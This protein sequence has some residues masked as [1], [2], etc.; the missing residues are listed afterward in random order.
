MT[1]AKRGNLKLVQ[2]INRSLVLNLIRDRGPLSRADISRITKLTRSTVSEIV[3]YLI[4]EGWVRENGRSRSQGGR[5]GILVELNPR[6]YYAVGVEIGTLNIVAALVDLRGKVTKRV[7]RL[8]RREQ[9]KEIVIQRVKKTIHELI[10]IS[11]VSLSKIA[12]IGVAVPGLIDSER[13]I[14]RVSSN[15]G[16][17][18]V[19]LREILE[20]E[21]HVPILVDNNANAMALAESQFGAGKG[22]KNFVCVNVGM[23]IGSGIIIKGEIYRGESESAG[24]IGHTTVDYNGPICSC[25]NRGCL[26]VMASAPAIAK[27]AIQA[28]RR[29][30]KTKIYQ[31]VN[32]NLNEITAATVAMAAKEGD[33]I[34]KRIMEETGEYLGTG[35][36][37]IVNLFNPRVVIMGGGVSQAGNL[38]FEP[39]KRTIKER[40]FF[41]P[42]EVVKVLPPALG[43]DSTVIGAATLVLDELFKIP[44]VVSS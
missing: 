10:S 8:T 1:Y 32:G 11:K 24:E 31:M 40:A 34:A 21:F 38:I 4:K 33:K 19:P 18:N 42:A 23:G 9:K 44:K 26:E 35:I 39:I 36:A 41:V 7:E 5:R 43:K 13:G 12:G 15:L 27:R 16:W 14:L 2:K 37:N 20:N 30:E 22:I 6:A 3:N 28:I 29:G 17:R 25:G